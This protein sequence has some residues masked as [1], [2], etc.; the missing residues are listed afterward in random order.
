VALAESAVPPAAI[1]VNDADRG[2]VTR[3]GRDA[4][5][6]AAPVGEGP[7]ALDVSIRTGAVTGADGVTGAGAS[8]GV[9]ARTGTGTPGG[10]AVPAVPAVHGV[11]GVPAVSVAP[12]VRAVDGSQLIV[13]PAA[14]PAAPTDRTPL[15]GHAALAPAPGESGA[16]LPGRVPVPVVLQA[17]DALAL[18]S[19]NALALAQ[20]ALAQG[21]A[22]MLL[23][24][25]HAV[26]AL[27]LVAVSGSPEAYAA[28]VHAL[29]PYPG[30]AHAAGEVR[31]LLGLPGRPAPR[32]GGRVQDPFGFRAFPQVHGC[33]LDASERLREIVE[34]EINCPSENPLMDPDG[35]AA[36][37][38][39][40]F[41]AAPLGLA[42]DAAGLAL[43]QTAQLSAARLAALG[44]PGLT[45]LPAFLGGGPA[46]SSGAMILEY[47]A[48]SALA[49]L[50]SCA[51]P[52]SAGH[53]VL[54]RG[55]EEAA[56]FAGQAA[57]QAMRAANA[58]TVVL[59]CELVAAV[60]ALRMLPGPPPV[61]AFAVAA[62]AL[63]AGTDDRPLTDD[64]TAAAGLLP[65]L[66]RM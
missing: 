30:A 51:T 33:A 35:A 34:V 6:T 36:Y 26:A 47:T 50:R 21:E 27:S 44:D 23:R 52:A 1:A 37:H 65:V 10:T 4:G 3:G 42:L 39:G 11:P 61:A 57:R 46:S 18:L 20:A 28:P 19:S 29:R 25:T 13:V 32:P 22:A 9:G 45:A 16:A 38:H 31:R 48:N 5:V 59:A 43:L 24:A 63:P 62:A 49:E 66:A 41:F 54:S 17:G 15:P 60:R 40:G 8:T 7:V 12:G 64:V 55:L 14:L 56:S 2:A 58:Y 53:A